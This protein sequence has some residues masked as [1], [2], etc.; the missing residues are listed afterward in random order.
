CSGLITRGS[1]P[2][3]SATGGSLPALTSAASWGASLNVFGSFAASVTTSGPSSLPM[4]LLPA[5]CAM[6]AAATQ[7]SAPATRAIVSLKRKVRVFMRAPPFPAYDLD[8]VS[9]ARRASAWG[10]PDYRD[11]GAAT[12]GR[13]EYRDGKGDSHECDYRGGPVVLSAGLPSA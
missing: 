7:L 9:P 2:M 3:R 10:G 8:S 5:F 4:R 6:A 1:W 13:P 12:Q 11:Y